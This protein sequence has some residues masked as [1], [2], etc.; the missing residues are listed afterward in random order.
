MER[1]KSLLIAASY[2]WSD[3]L[4]AFVFSHGPASPTL[5]DVLM[6]TGLDISTADNSHLF[7]TKPSSKVETHAIGGWSEYIQKYR[8]TR[9]IGEREQVIFLNMWL[10]KFV[11]CGRLAG[12]TYVYLSAAE[13]LANGGRFPLGRYLLGS[14][15]HLLHQVAKKL[16]L[17]QSISNLGG[18]WWFVN[19]WLS[20]HMHKRL[21]FDLFAQH[22]PRDIAED[23]ELD[24]EVSASRSPLNYG[25]AAIVLPGTS[26]N[27]D[28]VSRFFQTLYE[29][30]AKD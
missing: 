29:G 3:T 10:D 26:G 30:L 12:P 4:N 14:V 15:Y 23:H 2:F 5:A 6:L 9:P 20:V 19:M 13:R 16:L 11:F 18:P 21:G 24:E 28:Q 22:F 17:G 27:E 8:K 1:N 25:E 7:D